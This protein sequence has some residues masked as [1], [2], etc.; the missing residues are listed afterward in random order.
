[1]TAAHT[2]LP[3]HAGTR[4]NDTKALTAAVIPN[5]PCTLARYG[6]LRGKQNQLDK[7]SLLA[8]IPR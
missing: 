1:M 4:A 8:P 7:S 6:M 5:C 3:Y 2:E